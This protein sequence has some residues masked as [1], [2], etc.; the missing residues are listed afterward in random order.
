MY[1]C[2]FMKDVYSLAVI[3]RTLFY[4]NSLH[5]NVM[6]HVQMYRQSQVGC[7]F[8]CYCSQVTEET[9]YNDGR[10][11]STRTHTFHIL[12]HGLYRFQDWKPT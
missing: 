6:E 10:T 3:L 11:M 8:W 1:L 4:I 12:N 5:V 7:M 9:G 2:G